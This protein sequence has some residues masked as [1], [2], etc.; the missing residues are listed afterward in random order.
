MAEQGKKVEVRFGAFTCSIEGYDNP[1]EQMREILG[2]MQRM[3]TETPALAEADPDFDAQQI[4]SAMSGKTGEGDQ[5]TTPGVVVI[6]SSEASEEASGADDAEAADQE[7]EEIPEAADPEA[8]PER[9]DEADT[10]ETLP[11]SD[12]FTFLANSVTPKHTDR[13]SGLERAS[14]QAAASLHDGRHTEADTA[15]VEVEP[16]PVAEFEDFSAEP[17]EAT[18]EIT[19]KV[20]AEP[21]AEPR[22]SKNI[23]GTPEPSPAATEPGEGFNIFASPTMRATSDTPQTAPSQPVEPVVPVQESP[24]DEPIRQEPATAAQMEAAED[25]PEP[26]EKRPAI[27]FDIRKAFSRLSRDRKQDKPDASTDAASTTTTAIATPQ[28]SAP[29]DE[30]EAPAPRASRETVNVTSI[31][32]PPKPE[33]PASTGSATDQAQESAPTTTTPAPEND[34][35][36]APSR[37]ESLLSRVHGEPMVGAPA[38]PA[39]ADVA[40]IEEPE[41]LWPEPAELAQRGGD[42]SVSGQ[43]AA[44]AAWLTIVQG[45]SRITRRE[46]MEVLEKIPTETPRAL[47][48]RI[49]GFGKLVRSGTLILVDDGLF[50]LAQNERERFRSMIDPQV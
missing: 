42:L 1:V 28:A 30:P 46:V 13:V 10:N 44:S 4:E 21:E 16:Q 3:I 47:A 5:S 38:D 6:R 34:A 8:V 37:F 39:P 36:K 31:F 7:A 14:E 32:A 50:A 2:M 43:L 19:R 23:F 17:E 49:K 12:P 48:D 15:P 45:K 33:E 26:K 35:P 22:V 41:Q 11:D 9:A 40:P 18:E 24:V 20:E 27:G 25:K 29:T